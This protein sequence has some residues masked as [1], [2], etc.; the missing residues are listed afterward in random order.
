MGRVELRTIRK[1][2]RYFTCTK[3]AILFAHSAQGL[4]LYSYTNLIIDVDVHPMTEYF[5]ELTDVSLTA[6]STKS[7]K[8]FLIVSLKENK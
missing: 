2:Y 1:N 8:S 7:E 6:F 3:L 4:L 5:P